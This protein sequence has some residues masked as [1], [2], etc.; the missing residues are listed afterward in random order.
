MWINIYKITVFKADPYN[1]EQELKGPWFICIIYQC[2]EARLY[3]LRVCAFAFPEVQNVIF[4][5]DKDKNIFR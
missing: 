5:K 4:G 3:N 1:F 2:R